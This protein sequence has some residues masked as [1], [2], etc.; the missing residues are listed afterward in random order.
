MVLFFKLLT[1]EFTVHL[2]V[3]FYA[4]FGCTISCSSKLVNRGSEVKNSTENVL[5]QMPIG[6][7]KTFG[8]EGFL[9]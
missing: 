4:I 8:Y 2:C 9:V 6:Q 3:Q 7:A 5:N 1:L